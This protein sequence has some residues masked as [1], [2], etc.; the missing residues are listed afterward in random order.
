MKIRMPAG[1]TFFIGDI[2][3]DFWRIKIQEGNDPESLFFQFLFDKAVGKK[4]AS[5]ALPEIIKQLGAVVYFKRELV[6]VREKLSYE[7]AHILEGKVAVQII[8]FGKLFHRDAILKGS[9][10]VAAYQN[11]FVA[12]ETFADKTCLFQ[13][14]ISKDAVSQPV[15]KHME[16]IHGMTYGNPGSDAGMFLQVADKG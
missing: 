3:I 13:G 10:P 6:V 7:F 9:V 14:N 15:L 16:Q 2:V 8:Q 5:Q 12:G 11:Q 4:A 1:G